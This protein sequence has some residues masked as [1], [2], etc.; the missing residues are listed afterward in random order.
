MNTGDSQARQIGRS[1]RE[2]QSVCELHDMMP[3]LPHGNYSSLLTPPI[4]PMHRGPLWSR[5]AL[6]LM[7][8]Q[9]VAKY[10]TFSLFGKSELRAAPG[11]GSAAVIEPKNPGDPGPWNQR[12]KAIQ[13]CRTKR[14]YHH[15]SEGG[16]AF[17]A[18]V[19]PPQAHRPRAARKT[20]QNV[21]CWGKFTPPRQVCSAGIC[22]F[23]CFMVF[24]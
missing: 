5:I 21:L 4:N 14:D 7:P 9:C 13:D 6:S 17:S 23:V 2:P 11:P 24:R 8:L 12:T 1:E 15:K 18:V 19:M 16:K 10:P 3:G 22:L 20:K